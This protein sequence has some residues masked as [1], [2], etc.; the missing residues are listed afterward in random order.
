[1]PRQLILLLLLTTPLFAQS[2]N[3]TV[4]TT[5]D[6][7]QR[8][9]KLLAAAKA[10][11]TGLAFEIMDDFGNDRSMIIV[12]VHTGAPERH[13]MWVDQMVI[14]KGTVTLVTGG[15]MQ[16]EHPN[17]TSPGETLGTDLQGGKEVVLH[18]GDIAHVPAGVPHQV[19]LAPGTTAAYLAFKEKK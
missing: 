5:A 4:H 8:E 1:M 17:G 19:K 15:S 14:L 12:R 11:P 13:Q 9:V 16:G 18:V 7:H 6:L 3:P 2:T 10:A